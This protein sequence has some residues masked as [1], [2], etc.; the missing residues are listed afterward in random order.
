MSF[1]QSDAY[2]G[3]V[4]EAADAW[5]VPGPWI[6]DQVRTPLRIDRHPLRRHNAHQRV[7]HGASEL[8]SIEHHLAVEVENRGHALGGVLDVVVAALSQRVPEQDR[9]L[10][11]V[12]RIVVPASPPCPRGGRLLS[13]GEVVAESLF[14]AL[15]E[16]FVGE[17]GALLEYDRDLGGD[18]LAASQLRA[19]IHD[20]S[21][22]KALPAAC[23][24][25]DIPVRTNLRSMLFL[26]KRGDLDAGQRLWCAATSRLAR[27]GA[28]LRLSG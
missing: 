21:S 6:D 26:E 7:V 23:R 27:G 1:A 24:V 25:D 17:L 3:V 12:Q 18:V 10:G 4:L 9:A 15:R 13:V 14:H 11:E 22:R 16:P 8:P 2:L 19:G 28:R 5:P 20:C